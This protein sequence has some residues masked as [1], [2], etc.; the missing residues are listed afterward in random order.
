MS[1]LSRWHSMGEGQRNVHEG[2]DHEPEA[3]K[4]PQDI[5]GNEVLEA[6]QE[7][8]NVAV[9]GSASGKDDGS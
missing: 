8:D 7:D 1:D 4:T 6:M 5:A 2:E 9:S 3:A